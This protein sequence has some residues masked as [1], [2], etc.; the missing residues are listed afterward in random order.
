MKTNEWTYE[1]MSLKLLVN[2][3]KPKEIGEN[4]GNKKKQNFIQQTNDL[5][6]DVII[7]GNMATKTQTAG[8]LMG[9]PTQ[10]QIKKKNI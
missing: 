7:V 3:K 9:N 8:N 1:E 5:K 2:Q 4:P 6:E 10:N